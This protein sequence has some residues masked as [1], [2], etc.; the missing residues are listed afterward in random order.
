MCRYNVVLSNCSVGEFCTLHN[1]ACIGQDGEH[2]SMYS[3]LKRLH[4]IND[5]VRDK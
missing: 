3:V 5:A 2:T 4:D 1:G